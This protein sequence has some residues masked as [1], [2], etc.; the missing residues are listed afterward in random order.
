MWFTLPRRPT[1]RGLKMAFSFQKRVPNDLLRQHFT[2]PI[3]HPIQVPSN[4]SSLPDHIVLAISTC[5]VSSNSSRVMPPEPSL[6]MIEKIWHLC[7][8]AAATFW[9][10][11]CS[12]QLQEKTVR[13][14]S[15]DTQNEGRGPDQCRKHKLHV[16]IH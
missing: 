8:I 4:P 2:H 6:S 12:L 16:E 3:A 10:W 14:K 7:W 15:A 11:I 1:R 9:E 5:Q 13:V